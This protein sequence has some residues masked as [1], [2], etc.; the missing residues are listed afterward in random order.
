M[1]YLERK[2]TILSLAVMLKDEL[3]QDKKA[4]GDVFMEATGTRGDII[5]H[6]T[7]YFL[8]LNQS[9]LTGFCKEIHNTIEFHRAE[10][11]L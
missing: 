3:S 1:I 9:G 8:L 4:I 10:K 6:S 2:K 5:K 11:N 7:G